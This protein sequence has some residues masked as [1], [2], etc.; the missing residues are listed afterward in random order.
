MFKLIL[1]EFF[2]LI[3]GV[4]SQEPAA[5]LLS[6]GELFLI[7]CFSNLWQKKKKLSYFI[8][9]VL[10][11]IF[12]L[13]MAFLYHTGEYV[14]TIIVANLNTYD[15]VGTKIVVYIVTIFASLLISFFPYSF[16]PV[17]S[18]IKL[19]VVSAI[20]FICV[21]LF[22]YIK[23]NHNIYSPCLSLLR[24]TVRLIRTENTIRQYKKADKDKILA[25]FYKKSIPANGAWINRN[26]SKPA[27]V[28]VIFTEGMSTEIMDVFN[29][30]NLKLTPC[31]N[32]FYEKSLVFTNYYN[33][34]A[35]TF[36]GLR[37]Q[38]FSG[39]QYFG[40]YYN[41]GTGFGEMNKDK[42]LKY[43]ATKLISVVDILN[44]FGYTTFFI[45]T[46]PSNVQFTNY[47]ETFHFG[48]VFSGDITDRYL[49]DREAFQLLENTIFNLKEPFFIGMYNIG[50]HH[51]F[52]SPDLRYGDGKDSIL[53]KFHNYDAEFG[54]FFAH[55][56]E[57]DILDNTI[58]IFTT[59]HA[60]F[61]SPE[62]KR[63]FKSKQEYFV[64]TIPLFIYWNGIEHEIINA[65]GRNSLDLAPTILDLLKIYDHENYFL[66]SSL[67]LNNDNIFNKI[68]A[69]GDAFYHTGGGGVTPITEDQHYEIKL[70]KEY[71]S[72][73]VNFD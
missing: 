28:I 27:N 37:G 71:Y 31:L 70:I 1:V 62:Y 68:S 34:T 40:G 67:F 66:G 8:N 12:L 9:S 58:L 39:Y 23:S 2:T 16:Q 60:A 35:A 21:S 61:N 6:T 65:D 51:G 33:H 4:R 24:T 14:N 44:K 26:L 45:N 63:S 46:E 72:I 19:F 42:L 5:I 56:L 52:D 7:F 10:C 38:L 11:L 25:N 36:R 30:L 47:L 54:K 18:Q 20:I 73:S 59:D 50:T 3:A 32:E 69:L 13:Q 55:L 15:A 48:R 64:N 53:N 29:D 49:T 17:L 57:T 22:V 41:N 43:T